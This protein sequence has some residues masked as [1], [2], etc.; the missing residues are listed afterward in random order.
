MTKLEF[1]LGS[2][3]HLPVLKLFYHTA[4]GYCSSVELTDVE[5]I[6][7]ETHNSCP[8]SLEIWMT[9]DS[10]YSTSCSRERDDS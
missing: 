7:Q 3:Q 4:D 9:K 6:I 1:Q 5:V 10:S 8:S 2:K